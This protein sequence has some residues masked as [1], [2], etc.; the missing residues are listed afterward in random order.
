MLPQLVQFIAELAQL[1][2]LFI[3]AGPLVK[4]PKSVGLPVIEV[5]GNEVVATALVV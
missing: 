4:S 1:D 2:T 5:H 3:K